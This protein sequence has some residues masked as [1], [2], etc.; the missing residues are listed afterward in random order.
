[1]HNFEAL[2]IVVGRIG[3]PYGIKG[4]VHVASFTDP[5][6]NIRQ[7]EPWLLAQSDERKQDWTEV[8]EVETRLHNDRI[9][10][11]IGDSSSRNEATRLANQYIAVP[12][13]V[14]P[15]MSED[16]FLWADMD[17][18]AVFD[19]AGVAIGTVECILD[20][21]AHPILQVATTTKKLL[22]PV[23]AEFIA[24]IVPNQSIT[25]RWDPDWS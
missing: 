9:I 8:G 2:P 15:E 11:R 23:V 17:G 1:M 22:V 7:Y 21:P 19:E 14:L 20:N 16:E 13:T 25:V 6:D 18:V 5:F 24:E 10:A 12:P 3:K 4:W